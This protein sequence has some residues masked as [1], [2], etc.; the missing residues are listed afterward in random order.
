MMAKF[1]FRVQFMKWFRRNKVDETTEKGKAKAAEIQESIY[2]VEDMS[3][4]LNKF[5]S[6]TKTMGKLSLCC[7]LRR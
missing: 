6:T 4:D 2:R 7:S 3:R 5:I 1:Y